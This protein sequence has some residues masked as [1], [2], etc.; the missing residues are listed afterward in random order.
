[1]LWV[2]ILVI[3]L[4]G[5]GAIALVIVG[6]RDSQDSDPLQA[7]LAEFAAS[8]Q[9]ANLEDIELSQPITDRI[10]VPLARKFGEFAV[11]FTPQ[12]ALN[13]TGR[14]L[15]LAGNPRGLDAA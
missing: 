6:L 8:G 13:A 7:R 9:T 15:E 2:F 14:K 12:N 1:M 3:L 4:I 5:A 10:F 11:R